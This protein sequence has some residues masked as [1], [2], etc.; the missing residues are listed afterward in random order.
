MTSQEFRK[1]NLPDNPGVYFFKKGTEI[2]YIGKATSLRDRVRSYFSADL[3]KT[4]GPAIVDM[5]FQAN[6]ISHQKTDSVLEA[7]ILESNLI[8]KHQP[9]YN[10]KERDDKSFNYVGVTK[11]E[12]PRIILIRAKDLKT[13]IYKLQAK[14]GPFPNAGQLREAL[15]LIQKIFPFF[16]T[17][18]PVTEFNSI[19]KKRIG[20]NIQL[21]LY[22]DVFSGKVSKVEYN[23]NI[24]KIKL[25]FEGKTKRIISNLK[26]E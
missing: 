16:N 9:K 13:N 26:K 5:V 3:I 19:D 20:L 15:K 7:L 17:N 18:K 25:F 8:K 24:S 2:L 14:Y 4:R 22:P 6:D 1:K 10:V 23:K 11:E 12:F 21:G